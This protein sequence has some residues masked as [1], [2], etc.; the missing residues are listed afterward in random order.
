[1]NMA[2]LKSV[3]DV[4]CAVKIY[5]KP[6]NSSSSQP[7][8]PSRRWWGLCVEK[9]VSC[10]ALRSLHGV[11]RRKASCKGLDERDKLEKWDEEGHRRCEG[12]DEGC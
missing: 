4:E 11:V 2:D 12:V 6:R 9:I 10:C 7:T 3:C 1:M 5:T 8:F